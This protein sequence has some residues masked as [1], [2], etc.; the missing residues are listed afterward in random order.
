MFAVLTLNALNLP[1]TEGSVGIC[2][3]LP[4]QN[5]HFAHIWVFCIG[6]LSSS[7]RESLL[8]SF[9]TWLHWVF[10]KMETFLK[11]WMKNVNW[12]DYCRLEGRITEIDEG[13]PVGN[14]QER[15]AIFILVQKEQ[16]MRSGKGCN[17]KQKVTQRKPHLRRTLQCEERREASGF[18]CFTPMENPEKWE[19]RSVG[20][21][22]EGRGS[23]WCTGYHS[24]VPRYA[25]P[26]PPPPNPS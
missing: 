5:K 14:R 25:T 7:R 9:W 19:G 3:Y 6:S 17:P 20:G 11:A 24:L 1:Q 21:T 4:F 10:S 16:I 22:S 8:H 2:R 15:E 18:V 26:P 12:K 13:S 23:V